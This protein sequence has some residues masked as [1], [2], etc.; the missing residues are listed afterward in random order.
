MFGHGRNLFESQFDD[1]HGRW[2]DT[3]PTVHV[4]F[5]LQE[6]YL[7][8]QRNVQNHFRGAAI[9]LLWNSKERSFGEVLPIGR[10]PE[11]DIEGFLLELIGDGEATEE[12]AGFAGGDVEG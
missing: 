6:P 8:S 3:T 10:A 11:G 9:E 7:R 2:G 12:G 4:H 5:G 1:E